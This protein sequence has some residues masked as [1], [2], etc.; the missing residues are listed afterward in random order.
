MRWFV[1]MVMG[2]SVPSMAAD[3]PT[4]GG[5]DAV[6]RAGTVL[7]L[8]E[9]YGTAE[10]PAFVLDVACHATDADLPIVVTERG[11]LESQLE[12]AIVCE[13]EAVS[14]N[15]GSGTGGTPPARSLGLH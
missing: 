8:G 5:I 6:I 15:R 1:A 12:T 10:S 14:F 3:C 4:I 9:L 13:V 11:N 7:M 2:V